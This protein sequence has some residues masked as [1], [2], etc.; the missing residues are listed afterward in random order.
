MSPEE[1][2]SRNFEKEF[3]FSAT[4]SS[5]PGGQNVNKV[6]SRVELR[7]N[8]PDS[9]LLSDE[10][11][12]L[13]SH[14]LNRRLSREGELILVSQSERSQL[15]NK[16]SVVEKFYIIVA[17]VLTPAAKRKPTKPTASSVTRRIETKRDTGVKK[18]LR[19][20]KEDYDSE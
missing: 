20:L 8:I 16:R 12:Q 14:S 7:I 1:L 13:I 6:N 11:K 2:K 18:K 5:G 19:K 3:I 4:R 9:F 15:L 17:R 10:E